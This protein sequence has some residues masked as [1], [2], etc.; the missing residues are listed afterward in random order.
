MSLEIEIPAN[1]VIDALA[2]KTSVAKECRFDRQNEVTR[3]LEEGWEIASCSLVAG[4]IEAGE[5]PKVRL[6]LVPPSLAPYW[7]KK[8]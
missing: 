3:A 7:P 1:V 2:G 5:A 4:D 8:R 6:E